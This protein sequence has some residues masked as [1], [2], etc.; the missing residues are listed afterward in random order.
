MSGSGNNIEICQLCHFRHNWTACG[1]LGISP[2]FLHGIVNRLILWIPKIN[3]CQ[4]E[5]LATTGAVPVFW[6]YLLRYLTKSR[7]VCWAGFVSSGATT[8]VQKVF[9]DNGWKI[10]VFT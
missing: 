1:I 10:S 7:A 9:R 2:S 8:L 4:P 3:T 5:E 6:P